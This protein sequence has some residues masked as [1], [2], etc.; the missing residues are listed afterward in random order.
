M[1]RMTR[2]AII[3][4]LASPYIEMAQLKGVPRARVIVHHAL[5]NAWAPIV[6]VI[7][8]NLAY[9]VVGVVVVEVVFVYPGIGQMMVDCGVEPRHAG[10][11]GLR[12]DLR[13]DLHPA[14][15]VGRHHL[16]HH[17]SASACIQDDRGKQ[18]IS[19]PSRRAAPN[20][21]IR[22][23]LAEDRAAQRLVRHDRHRHLCDLR[24][25]RAVDRALWRSRDRRQCLPAGHARSSGSAP[26]RSAATCLLPP[27]LRRPQHHRHRVRHHACCPSVIGGTLGVFAAIHAAAGSTR[28]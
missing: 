25:L 11:A 4:L 6:T 8:F 22:L 10:G 18:G 28:S 1:M 13:G 9:L 26:T 3:N 5:P 15:S 27:D 21:R 7:A 17:Q 23:A 12:A 24:A 14:Q 20:L 2:A 16:D 19:A